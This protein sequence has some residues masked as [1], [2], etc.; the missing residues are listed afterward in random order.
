MNTPARDFF[1][2]IS[3]E[4]RI[5]G[6][7]PKSIKNYVNSLK[8]LTNT[9]R[10][11]L[12][13]ISREELKSFLDKM[14]SEGASGSTINQYIAALKF[15]NTYIFKRDMDL[16]FRYS[17]TPKK[18]PVVLSKKEVLKIFENE[19]NL[20]YKLMFQMMY[21][22][23]LR[24]NEVTNLKVKDIELEEGTLTV[25]QGK[26]KK[27]RVTI[28]SPKVIHGLAFFTQGKKPADYVFDS[29]LG[30]AL[31]HRSVQQQFK[32]ALQRSGIKKDATCHSLR[33][34][35][36]THLLENGTDLR[37]IQNLLGHASIKT[38]QIYTKVAVG[39]IKQI[40]SPL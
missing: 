1:E 40:E 3:R 28:L 10:K 13:I 6:Y 29:S 18:L 24:L 32:R 2:H 38:T 20:K 37:Y 26:G 19:K 21:G 8:S 17:R 31:H 23:G 39:K 14:L 27:D 9:L 36:A 22:S 7:S 11:P 16:D 25:R 34:T 33:H 12:K 5:K 4:M 30:G 35:F 15:I